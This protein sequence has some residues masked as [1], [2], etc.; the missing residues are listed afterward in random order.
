MMVTM[1]DVD[2]NSNRQSSK[3]GDADDSGEYAEVSVDDE[4]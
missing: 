1:F 4:A 3:N 2:N